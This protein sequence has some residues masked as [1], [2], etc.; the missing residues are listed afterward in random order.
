MNFEINHE[1]SLVNM[2][3][4]CFTYGNADRGSYYFDKYIKKYED[5]LGTKRFNGIFDMRLNYLKS[6]CTVHTDVYQDGE[7]C[8][9]NKLIHKP[10]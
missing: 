2:I 5:I 1:Q 8:S 7:G 4:S 10:I 9:Y 6:N 3:D